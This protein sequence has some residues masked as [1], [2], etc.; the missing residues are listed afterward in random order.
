[1]SL[2]FNTESLNARATHFKKCLWK[3]LLY[4]RFLFLQ[5]LVLMNVTLS[6]SDITDKLYYHANK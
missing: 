2:L 1:M 5:N 6:A 4:L 3:Y